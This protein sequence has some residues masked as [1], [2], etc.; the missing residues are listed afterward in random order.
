MTSRVLSQMFERIVPVIETMDAE[1]ARTA[2]LAPGV[3]RRFML[4]GRRVAS[5]PPYPGVTD[6]RSDASP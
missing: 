6:E 4:S 5:P 1:P 3:G 2:P